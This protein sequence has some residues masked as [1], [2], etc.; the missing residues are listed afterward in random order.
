MGLR[1][2]RGGG[3]IRGPRPR[4]A[5][6]PARI[7]PQTS[8]TSGVPSLRN[9]TAGLA[10]LQAGLQ[11]VSGLAQDEIRRRMEVAKREGAIAGAEAERLAAAEGGQFQ[12]SEEQTAFARAF[13]QAGFAA[14]LARLNL[15]ADELVLDTAVKSPESG[16]FASA[17]SQSVQ[18]IVSGLDPR[19]RSDVE[20]TFLERGLRQQLAM[21]RN[22]IAAE[23]ANNVSVIEQ[24]VISDQDFTAQAARAGDNET[25]VERSGQVMEG[26]QQLRDVGAI[27]DGELKVRQQAFQ[28]TIRE[29]SELG[30]LDNAVN[31]E[32]VEGGYKYIDDYVNR[33]EAGQVA[34]PPDEALA[35]EKRMQSLVTRQDTRLSKQ[36]KAERA[37]ANRVSDVEIRSLYLA[38][39]TGVGE[40]GQPVTEAMLDRQLQIMFATGSINRDQEAFARGFLQR[41]FAVETEPVVFR[42]LVNGIADGSMGLQD[43]LNAKQ[44][45]TGRDL[46]FLVDRASR[47]VSPTSAAFQTQEYSR[48]D[49]FLRDLF[50]LKPGFTLVTDQTNL[51]VARMVRGSSALVEYDAIVEE[52]FKANR[53]IS[54]FDVALGIAQR[55]NEFTGIDITSL[56]ARVGAIPA[57][58][59]ILKLI[60]AKDEASTTQAF[61]EL[62]RAGA[63][64]EAQRR[65]GLFFSDADYRTESNDLLAL[66]QRVR[67]RGVA[68][69][70]AR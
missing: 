6:A 54:E 45:L 20:L 59:S 12:P 14:Q 39:A 66:S 46:A 27:D 24:S 69:S 13:N 23:H 29:H 67:L 61:D 49:S 16:A 36:E 34:L 4:Q 60:D 56:Q 70:E 64:I 25:L 41:E 33:R 58:V 2:D 3:G 44:N 68:T 11:A 1:I 42:N 21:E 30:G 8:G 18:E 31:T 57:T 37:L 35:L 40:N 7:Q 5:R 50:G 17:Y 32:G 53:S 10:V 63:V 48:G 38:A 9:P 51:D 62:A 28:N 22:E 52:A 43:A 15:T 26:L 47:E 55:E 65:E 19:I